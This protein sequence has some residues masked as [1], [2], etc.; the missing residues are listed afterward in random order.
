MIHAGGTYYL[1]GTGRGIQV[2]SSPDLKEWTHLPPV[3]ASPPAW[4]AKVAPGFQGDI[5]AP[6]ISY[7]NGT[8]YV[9]FAVSA[10]GR[11]ASAIGLATNRT[12]DPKDPKYHWVDH[13]VVVR[14]VPGRDMWNAIDPQLFVDTDG[15]PWL[16]F[17]SF[18]G[19]IKLVKLAPGLTK[20]ADPPEWHTIAARNR[21]WKLDERDAGDAANPNLNVDSLYP[22]R[23]VRMEHD[24]QS[25]SIEAPFI[26]HAHGWYYLFVSWDRCCRGVNSTYKVVVGRS[27]DVRGPY[28]DRQGQKMIYGGGSMVVF[29]FGDGGRWAAGGHEAAYTFGGTDYLILHGYDATDHGRSRLIAR[30]IVWSSDGWPTVSLKN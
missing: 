26:F 22:R 5:W 3:F 30:P 24:M 25:G 15:T 28:V 16:T 14:S 6:D 4:A 1:F 9:Y 12:L 17:G 27:R 7:H 21:Y 8:Y 23:V 19:G 29:G 2:W 20:P 11:N 10:F 13:G 18:W